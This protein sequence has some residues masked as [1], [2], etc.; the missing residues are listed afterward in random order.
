MNVCVCVCVCFHLYVFSSFSISGVY[1][2]SPLRHAGRLKDT[3]VTLVSVYRLPSKFFISRKLFLI[4]LIFLYQYN[5][6]IVYLLLTNNWLNRE[7]YLP[8]RAISLC[9]AH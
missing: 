4:S 6:F 5:A 3:R 7:T 9:K 8:L 1:H 2:I